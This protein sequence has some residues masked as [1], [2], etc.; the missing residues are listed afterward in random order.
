LRQEGCLPVPA[1]RVRQL[2]QRLPALNG[3]VQEGP[4]RRSGSPTPD[5]SLIEVAQW[6]D[7]VEVS[8]PDLEKRRAASRFS[9]TSES[10]DV[11]RLLITATEIRRRDRAL[12]GNHLSSRPAIPVQRSGNWASVAACSVRISTSVDVGIRLRPAMEEQAHGP[13]VRVGV[14]VD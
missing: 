6:T 8:A 3:Y 11:A 12:F 9:P 4:F 7:C 13:G 14:F 2:P 5:T 10:A 1:F